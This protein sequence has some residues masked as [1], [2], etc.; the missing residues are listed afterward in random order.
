MK[1]HNITLIASTSA[2]INPIVGEWSVD[3]YCISPEEEWYCREMPY[4][5]SYGGGISMEMRVE[6]DM[7]GYFTYTYTWMIST[8][9]KFPISA[10]QTGSNTYDI[11]MKDFDNGLLQCSL[12]EP[13]LDCILF[14]Y[15]EENRLSF[16]RKTP[17]A[18]NETIVG[19]F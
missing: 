15:G 16:S 9:Y 7:D 5:F 11:H 19:G 18:N 10:V 1:I 8:P 13:E 4:S 12:T 3:E 17:I 6:A 14:A 2:C